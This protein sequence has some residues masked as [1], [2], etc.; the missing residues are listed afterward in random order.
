MQ[1]DHIRASQAYM[2]DILIESGV[3]EFDIFVSLTGN[4]NIITADQNEENEG[5]CN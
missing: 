5:H 4:F 1:V 2:N 3:S